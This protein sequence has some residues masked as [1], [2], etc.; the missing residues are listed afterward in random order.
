ML[1]SFSCNQ[2]SF[3][4]PLLGMYNSNSC[5]QDARDCFEF[6]EKYPRC[7]VTAQAVLDQALANAI[8]IKYVPIIGDGI[9]NSGLYNNADCGYEDGDVSV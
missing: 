6:N 1:V 2:Q 7:A 8:V 4:C 9:C 5:N 3:L